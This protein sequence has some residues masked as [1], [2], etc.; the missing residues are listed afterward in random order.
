MQAVE[1]GEVEIGAIHDVE[2]AGFGQE[3]VHDVD[4]VELAVG[5]VE[6]S[7]D[8]AAQIKQGV[9]LD[10]RFGLSEMSPRN[11]VRHRSMVEESSA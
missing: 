6:E 3:Q 9:K 11:M 8:L 5:Y 10:R 1:T 2:G 4:V 7:R